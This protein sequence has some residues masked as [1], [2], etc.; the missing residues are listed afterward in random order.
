MGMHG[1]KKVGSDEKLV[2]LIPFDSFRSRRESN[3]TFLA[4]ADRLHGF[5]SSNGFQDI[6]VKEEVILHEVLPQII[7]MIEDGGLDEKDCYYLSL[8]K[9]LSC[10]KK[11]GF[12]NCATTLERKLPITVDSI[13]EQMRYKNAYDQI[14]NDLTEQKRKSGEIQEKWDGRYRYSS[15]KFTEEEVVLISR[16]ALEMAQ[17]FDVDIPVSRFLNIKE[18]EIHLRQGLKELKKKSLEIEEIVVPFPDFQNN[19]IYGGFRPET[20]RTFLK[21]LYEI[22]LKEYPILVKN[23]FPQ[24][25]NDFYLFSAMPLRVVITTENEVLR[26]FC[27]VY[28]C[29]EENIR[30]SKVI[31]CSPKELT[32]DSKNK[33]LFV[34]ERELSIISEQ[35]FDL[36]YF[37]ISNSAE[38]FLWLYP[39]CSLRSLIYRR[40]RNEFSAVEKSLK[41]KY[42]QW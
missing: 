36:S 3:Q 25:Q 10:A 11:L 33:K 42:C 12:L 26:P 20:L 7:K 9:V 18:I 29:K 5:S 41:E 2:E 35:G 13:L 19:L 21:R 24:Y 28:F 34:K 32:F 15:T 40:I 17:N 14:S 4:G 38:D 31:T 1:F 39:F 37:L 16:K 30:E 27:R 23:N 8:E 6:S 22:F